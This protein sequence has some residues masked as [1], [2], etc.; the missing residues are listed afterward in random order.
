MSGSDWLMAVGFPY[1]RLASVEIVAQPSSGRIW[2]PVLRGCRR[3]SANTDDAAST[4][5][6]RA[7]GLARESVSDGISNG[8]A[9][10]ALAVDRI[11]AA[12]R[13][14][15]SDQRVIPTGPERRRVGRL[16]TGWSIT[17]P[18]VGIVMP[19]VIAVLSHF[20]G[21]DDLEDLVRTWGLGTAR[22]GTGWTVWLYFL[23]P[24]LF[25][26]PMLCVFGAALA[27]RYW[28]ATRCKMW[29]S[30][31]A[32]GGFGLVALMAL[33]MVILGVGGDMTTHVV[34]WLTCVYVVVLATFLYRL[35]GL[36]PG[37]DLKISDYRA[38]VVVAFLVTVG[39]FSMIIGIDSLKDI[40]ANS[41]AGA[42]EA[43][44][45]GISDG[46]G[47]AGV[48]GQGA[49]VNHV[50]SEGEIP[51]GQR[52]KGAELEA[53]GAAE[54]D[55]DYWVLAIF[56]GSSAI[57]YLISMLIYHQLR[58]WQAEWNEYSRLMCRIAKAVVP[59]EY[60]GS[61]NSRDKA[62]GKI[63]NWLG[64]G[65]SRSLSLDYSV[66]VGSALGASGQELSRGFQDDVDGALGE[67][68]SEV[69]KAVFAWCDGDRSRWSSLAYEYLY[70]RATHGI[71]VQLY[72]M[73]LERGHS[74]PFNVDP[75]VLASSR[76]LAIDVVGI[77]YGAKIHRVVPK[78]KKRKRDG[79]RGAA[80]G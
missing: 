33:G 72:R 2:G 38:S 51:G 15:A 56:F 7:L 60:G 9:D 62:C 14:A 12:I 37:V 55:S 52:Q 16:S 22:S 65:V 64:P 57:G 48:S 54:Q 46:S 20:F 8:A 32:L 63:G 1:S 24:A 68:L 17:I 34:I 76:L 73:E 53:A 21:L 10:Q 74:W 80:G 3:M 13:G 71:A 40:N 11:A 78:K 58:R 49:S 43:R 45:A 27:A 50:G 70:V 19:I 31:L 5:R 59:P 36:L 6:G 75:D 39:A 61:T 26:V 79:L 25:A 77:V 18:A 47:N 44:A 41:E 35:V 28:D 67:A 30:R 4:G 66:Y 69:V 23:P 42:Q 29:G